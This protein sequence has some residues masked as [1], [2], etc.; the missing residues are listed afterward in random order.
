MGM[1]AVG[2]VWTAI[3]ASRAYE[4]TRGPDPKP[5]KVVKNWAAYR[6]G[7]HLG[8][9]DPGVT[10][11]AF[12]DPS[13]GA[14]RRLVQQ[15]LP[16]LERYPREVALSVRSFPLR[17]SAASPDA[18][19]AMH[20]VGEQHAGW[21]YIEGLYGGTEDTVPNA[22]ALASDEVAD[23]AIFWQC[24]RATN[25]DSLL[26]RALD[27]ASRLGVH[28]VP[29]ILVN[30]DMYRGLPEGFVQAVESRLAGERAP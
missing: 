17:L 27:D 12:M 21:T 3:N 4:L 6:D 13:C 18:V 10:I 9:D 11:V 25:G 26:R 28:L 20:C 15:V 7:L 5:W 24:M 30:A 2:G 29:T 16:L 19:A 22:I 23:S 1:L 14:C 8:A